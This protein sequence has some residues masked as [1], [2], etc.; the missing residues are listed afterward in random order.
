MRNVGRCLLPSL[1]ALTGCAADS[2]LPV[3][4]DAGGVISPQDRSVGP[5]VR[6]PTDLGAPTDA[7]VAPSDISAPLDAAA[8]ADVQN[9]YDVVPQGDAPTCDGGAACS[10]R[11]EGCVAREMCNDGLDNNCDGQADETCPCIPGSVQRCSL[12]P[13]GRRGVGTCTDGNQTCVGTGEFGVWS[14][15]AGAL[16]PRGESC[17]GADNDCDGCADNGLCCRP[18]G[19]CPAAGDPRVPTGA[20]FA[21]YS[22][23][24]TT[25]FPG[26]ATRWQWRVEG[27]PCDRL[28]HATRG[29]VSYRLEGAGSDPRAAEGET[30]AFTPTLSGDYTVTLTVTAADGSTF[31]C[32]F[33][34]AVRAPGLRVE[35]CWDRTGNPRA[36][37]PEAGADIDLW[38]QGPRVNGTWGFPP[39]F[40]DD[41][42]CGP[43][44]CFNRD[45][46]IPSIFRASRP[47]WGYAPT[48]GGACRTPEGGLCK[49][50]RLDVD[51]NGVNDTAHS[52]TDPENINVDAPRAGERFRVGAYYWRGAVPAQPMVNIYCGGALRA[53]FGGAMVGGAL[54]GSAP[55][56]GFTA[57]GGGFDRA[58]SFWRV[59]D[60]TMRD[61]ATGCDVVP[62]VPNGASSGACVATNTDRS[63]DG[64]CRR[65]P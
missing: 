32:T 62:L 22:L 13:P 25:F 28:I 1:L 4:E 16:A 26:A 23:R 64:A 27:G 20:P 19:T 41:H 45:A 50:P 37:G 15:C 35:L 42:T 44:N 46:D 52:D 56:G 30:L 7:G 43:Y 49:N 39:G 63:F 3:F 34:V 40:E 2:G 21:R 29:R 11:P 18:A 57:G 33:V 6:P 65:R 24:G 36:T 58:S 59:A 9:R 54:Y 55:V 10:P 51:N 17:D 53:T 5:D 60:V 12:A 14:A 47:D 48:P 61:G 38:V 31:T 8:G